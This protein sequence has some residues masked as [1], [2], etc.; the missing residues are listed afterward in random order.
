MAKEFNLK[1]GIFTLTCVNVTE[2]DKELKW[3]K[4]SYSL[5]AAGAA[6]ELRLDDRTR[7]KPARKK[8]ILHGYVVRNDKR[9]FEIFYNIATKKIECV[10]L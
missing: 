1:S 4:A 10:V 9:I 2:V 6:G 5:I 7:L 3:A 8:E